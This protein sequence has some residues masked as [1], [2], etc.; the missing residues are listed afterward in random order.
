MPPT[1]TFAAADLDELSDTEKSSITFC[2][3]NKQLRNTLTNIKLAKRSRAPPFP[4]TWERTSSTLSGWKAK[5]WRLAAARHRDE[6]G[7]GF[8]YLRLTVQNDGECGQETKRRVQAGWNMWR[9]V[10]GRINPKVFKTGETSDVWPTNWLWRKNV[11][12]SWRCSFRSEKNKQDH[13]QCWG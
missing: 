13:L 7:V 1:L 8:Q 12:Q 11:K 2:E 5:K 4:G 10:S 9:K 6:E 3:D